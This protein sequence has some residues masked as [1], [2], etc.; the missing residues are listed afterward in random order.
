MKH[1][2]DLPYDAAEVWPAVE[3][4]VPALS[5]QLGQVTRP[6]VVDL[7]PHS[8]ATDDLSVR[9]DVHAR[10]RLPF[11]K[12]LPQDHGERVRIDHLVV[13]LV[14][15]HLGGGEGRWGVG[16]VG[17][18]AGVWVC[19]CAG[20]CVPVCGYLMQSPPFAIDSPP[21]PCSARYPSA[22]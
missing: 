8:I 21:A 5:K 12:H 16:G 4:L 9:V 14:Q 15:C 1:S 13:R 11:V 2:L 19:G 17:E 22:P 20:R 6:R 10:E 7:G 18:C 3:V